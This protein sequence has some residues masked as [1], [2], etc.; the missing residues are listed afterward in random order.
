ME[1]P[2]LWVEV[3]FL[4]GAFPLLILTQSLLLLSGCAHQ[5]RLLGGTSHQNPPPKPLTIAILPFEDQTGTYSLVGTRIESEIHNRLS[6]PKV[7]I[8]DNLAE[9]HTV[10]PR[11]VPSDN[12]LR[13]AVEIS[14]SDIE[15]LGLGRFPEP[16]SLLNLGDAGR[17]SVRQ[18]LGSDLLLVGAVEELY[19]GPPPTDLSPAMVFGAL[20][21][22]MTSSERVARA[23][24]RVRVFDITSGK[25]LWSGPVIATA[26]SGEKTRKELLS[27]A[28]RSASLIAVSQ[29]LEIK[30]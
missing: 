1:P 13:P 26:R 5:Y 24:F 29:L 16:E 8:I 19:Y 6:Q 4:L 7:R 12:F 20:G 25:L 11:I 22:A 27:Q 14:D 10:G 28:T 2:E 30:W 15:R 21:A 9:M 3:R 18:A 17:E 23:S